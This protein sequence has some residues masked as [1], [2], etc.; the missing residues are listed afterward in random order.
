MWD[1]RNAYKSLVG[2]P[3]GKRQ[4]EE[5][6]HTWEDMIEVDLMEIGFEKENWI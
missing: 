3:Q 1:K 2:K 4:L 6:R 5:R